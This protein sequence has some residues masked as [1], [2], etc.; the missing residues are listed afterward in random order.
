MGRPRR[1]ATLGS[2]SLRVLLGFG[3][4]LAIGTVLLVL[5][6]AAEDGTATNPLDA[7][8]TAVSAM[9]VTGLV[10]F[11]TQQ[12]WSLFGEIVIA[13][14][15]QI[16]GLGYMMGATLIF[17]VF[18][19]RMG[20]R[21]QH[22]LRLYYGAPSVSEA[23]GF[24][25]TVALYAA[26]FQVL[27][28]VL[29]WI[30]FSR[31]GVGADTSIWW[32][33]F[34][35]ISSFNNAGFNV[36]GT[37][38]VPWANDPFLLLTVAILIIAGGL[39]SVPVVMLLSRRSPAR[40][41]LDTRLILLT[42]LALLLI[43]TVYLAAAEWTNEATF[44]RVNPFHRVVLAFFQ[45]ATPRTAGFS[46]V[47]TGA[48]TDQ[49]KFLQ[50][51]L[52]FVGGSA[53]SAAG[54][55]KVGTFSVLLLAMLATFRG[56]SEIVGLGRRVDAMLIR[57]ALTLALL[58][59]AIVFGLTF[60]LLTVSDAPFIDVLFEAQSALST[61]GL[62]SGLTPHWNAFG[63][64]MLILG[65]LFG[66]FGPLVLVLEMTRSRPAVPRHAPEDSI[67]LG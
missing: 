36:T 49:A 56:R 66:R 15:M 8:F 33:I 53:G 27:G 26:L 43:G 32:G 13:V 57:Q 10:V 63:K 40:L 9:C 22:L 42:T 4:L 64:V 37:D 34:H 23:L 17:W 38:L 46:A 41:P 54:G 51:G 20:L 44:E 16:G 18:G 45:S 31:T 14:L 7:L 5:P 50:V 52:M 61:V 59:V 28:A 47:D 25:K 58:F 39:G 24:M 19:R 3:T 30:A 11:D 1:A 35:S 55:L 6:A 12:H 65:M 21:D 67:R 48:M 60:V 29:L 2:G 62:S